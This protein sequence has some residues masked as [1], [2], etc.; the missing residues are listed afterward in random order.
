MATI[1]IKGYSI[2]GMFINSLLNK[3]IEMVVN[4]IAGAGFSDSSFYLRYSYTPKLN[5]KN[6]G[7]FIK[8]N[9]LR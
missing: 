9:E 8:M 1:Y 6:L 4:F 7:Y 3:I 5:Q 2:K